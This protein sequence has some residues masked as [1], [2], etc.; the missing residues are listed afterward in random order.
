MDQTLGPSYIERREQVHVVPEL[1]RLNVIR[2]DSNMINISS[3]EASQVF[4]SIS[5]SMGNDMTTKSKFM[6]YEVPSA[7]QKINHQ[8]LQEWKI[9]EDDE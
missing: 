7:N 2:S 9:G 4:A 6:L 5:H 1:H 3:E 8:V